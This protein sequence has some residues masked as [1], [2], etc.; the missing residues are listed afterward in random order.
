M[1][2]IYNVA[3][4]DR[5]YRIFPTKPAEIVYD[6]ASPAQSPCATVVLEIYSCGYCGFICGQLTTHLAAD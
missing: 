3:T 1:R 2:K 6:R 5:W 4:D